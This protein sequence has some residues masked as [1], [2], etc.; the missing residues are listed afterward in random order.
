MKERENDYVIK[1]LRGLNEEY[2]QA[3]SQI[4]MMSPLPSITKTFSLILQQ[5]REFGVS[6]PTPVTTTHTAAY[7][8]CSKESTKPATFNRGNSGSSRG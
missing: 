3:R 2:S 7:N 4:R 5:E 6:V 8:T 1:F